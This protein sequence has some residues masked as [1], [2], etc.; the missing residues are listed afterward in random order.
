[1]CRTIVIWVNAV[2]E[3]R[4]EIKSSDED[5]VLGKISIS[6]INVGWTEQVIF[7]NTQKAILFKLDTGAGCNVVNYEDF[8][9]V[10]PKIQFEKTNANLANYNGTKISILSNY[11]Q[12]TF[13]FL[14]EA[15]QV[16][17][18]AKFLHVP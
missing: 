18:L 4:L 15:S 9:R 7:T 8:K 12:I 11:K 13:K 5:Y 16:N 14:L 6:N 3:N 10:G 1:M 2:E 17:H